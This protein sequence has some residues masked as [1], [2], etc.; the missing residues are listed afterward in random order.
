[1][2]EQ[3]LIK[4][5]ESLLTFSKYSSIN[6][7][8]SHSL[9]ATL[10]SRIPIAIYPKTTTTANHVLSKEPTQ[11]CPRSV[12]CELNPRTRIRFDRAGYVNAYCD[13]GTSKGHLICPWGMPVAAVS[14][15]PP[16]KFDFCINT[17]VRAQR[18][19]GLGGQSGYGV[20]RCVILAHVRYLI[21]FGTE[22]IRTADSLNLQSRSEN[23][24]L[25]SPS[26]FTAGGSIFWSSTLW[27]HICLK[28]MLR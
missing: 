18:V 6:I 28:K 26:V 22:P 25:N 9:L 8:Q 3:C 20:Q 1:M 2:L 11:S 5:T 16:G 7:F 4:L 24:T 15:N 17:W 13:S 10:L 12:E 23:V 19:G 14:F 27:V 21:P